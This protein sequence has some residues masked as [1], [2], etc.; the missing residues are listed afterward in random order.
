[1]RLTLLD[2][3]RKRDADYIDECEV[4]PLA[5]LTGCVYDEDDE[6]DIVL[7]GDYFLK[8]P[9]RDGGV[10]FYCSREGIA[11]AYCTNDDSGIRPVLENIDTFDDIIKNKRVNDNNEYEVEFGIYPNCLPSESLSNKLS[12]MKNRKELKKVGK[13]TL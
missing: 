11:D 9:D 3:D 1:M 12:S 10:N 4:T 2:E 8:T 13:N 6:E 7:S 5:I